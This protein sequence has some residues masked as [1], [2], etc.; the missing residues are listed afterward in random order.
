MTEK[1]MLVAGLVSMCFE[2]ALVSPTMSSPRFPIA[3]A[4]TVQSN[5]AKPQMMFYYCCFLIA[6]ASP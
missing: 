6:M 2:S 3:W 4:S 1:S 5:T